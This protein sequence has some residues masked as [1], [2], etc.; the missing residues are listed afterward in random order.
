M[1]RLVLA[2]TLGVFLGL[3]SLAMLWN[4]I[5]TLRY[6]KAAGEY[7]L[8]TFQ[9]LATLPLALGAYWLWKRDHRAI[10]ATAVGMALCAVVGT[11][12]ATYWT[13]PSER[14]SA[15]L[16]ALGASIVLLIVVVWLARVALKTPITESAPTP[17]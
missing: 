8:M 16:G 11:I 3:L 6:A 12:A 9:V 10:L 17:L 4:G 5:D 1:I 13:E 7:V 15:G 2:R 14:M